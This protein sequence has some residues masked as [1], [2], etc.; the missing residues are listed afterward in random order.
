MS[1]R[2][3]P[4]VRIDT[5]AKHVGE[6]VTLEGWLYNKR[7]SKKIHFLEVRDGTGIVQCVLPN[8]DAAAFESAGAAGQE[9]SLRVTGTVRAEP[10][11][12]GGHEIHADGFQLIQNAVDY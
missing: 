3:P 7:S 6:R 1:D 10:R 12:K 11:A 4:A 5:L 8:D 9:S 2:T